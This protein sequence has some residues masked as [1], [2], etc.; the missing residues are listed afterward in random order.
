MAP[1]SHTYESDLPIEIT[2]PLSILPGDVH[3]YHLPLPDGF[4]LNIELDADGPLAVRLLDSTTWELATTIGAR[5]AAAAHHAVDGAT[6]SQILF[7]PPAPGDYML[8]L[9]NAGCLTTNASL[10]ISADTNGSARIPLAPTDSV[11]SSPPR[12]IPH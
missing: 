12:S 11:P 2:E 6:T 10:T 5:W 7:I 8:L 4:V 1:R 9:W 3:T